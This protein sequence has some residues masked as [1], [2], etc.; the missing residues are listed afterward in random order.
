MTKV[1]KK[2]RIS[3]FG[4]TLDPLSLNLFKNKGLLRFLIFNYPPSCK[5]QKKNERK[6]MLGIFQKFYHA[7]KYK[8]LQ[9]KKKVIKSLE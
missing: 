3:Y 9:T 5:N 8:N 6:R 4:A 7:R 2:S 1:F